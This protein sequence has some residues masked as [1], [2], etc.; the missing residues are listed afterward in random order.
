MKENP[1]SGY[2]LKSGKVSSCGCL[3]KEVSKFSW[4]KNATHRMSGTRIWYI[5]QSMRFRCKRHKNYKNISVC[6]EWTRF[7]P[8]Y[9]WAI[10]NGY[11]DDLT[12]DRID[13]LGNY[14]PNNCRWADYKTQGNNK[15]TNV[16]IE[17]DGVTHTIAEWADITGIESATIAWRLHHGWPKEDMFIKPDLANRVKRRKNKNA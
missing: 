12:I 3:R 16:R 6:K 17:Y 11:S 9:D 1:T 2:D 8:F 13:N 7:E 14:E 15:S 4:N 5:W 10:N